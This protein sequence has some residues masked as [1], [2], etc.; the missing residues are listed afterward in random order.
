M[1]EIE[2]R[3]RKR[4]LARIKRDTREISRADVLWLL[5]EIKQLEWEVVKLEDELLGADYA[6]EHA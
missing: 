2:Q 4:R 1:T 6:S 3:E 5:R